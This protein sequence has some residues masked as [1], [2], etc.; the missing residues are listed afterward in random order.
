MEAESGGRHMQVPSLYHQHVEV[1]QGHRG[2]HAAVRNR[3]HWRER[4]GFKNRMNAGRKSSPCQL[5]SQEPG[6]YD[7]MSNCAP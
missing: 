6:V 5:Q 7:D 1:S 4:R 2:Q 3:R